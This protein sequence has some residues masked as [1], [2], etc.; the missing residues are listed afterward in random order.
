M[1]STGRKIEKATRTTAGVLTA[2]Q[3]EVALRALEG[4]PAV[5]KDIKNLLDPKIPEP[6]ALPEKPQSDAARDLIKRNIILNRI[7]R[8]A[9]SGTGRAATIATSPLGVT[10]ITP[11]TRRTLQAA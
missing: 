2:G 10:G 1:G 4:K 9:F 8:A 5:G 6:G 7:R 3:S 11:L